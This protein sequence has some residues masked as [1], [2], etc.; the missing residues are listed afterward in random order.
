[1]AIR[2][3]SASSGSSGKTDG[4]PGGVPGSVTWE[5]APTELT[6]RTA[7]VC[8]YGESGSGRTTF[9]LTAPG[10][11]ALLHASEKIEGIVQPFAKK[12]DIRILDFGGIFE[13]S[14]QEIAKQA[15]VK[16][17][18]VKAAID[19]AFG[20]ARTIVLDTH[21]E[22]WELM[23]LARFGKLS[24]VLP[25]HYGPLNAEWRTLFKR[26][27]Q[28]DSVNLVCI[29][30]IRERYRNDKPTGKMEQAGQ[31]EMT[32]FSDAVVRTERGKNGDF[33]GVI[34]KGWMN[35]PSEGMELDGEMLT[36]GWVLGLITGT[37]KE[38]WER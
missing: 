36:F 10:P 26:F 2:T 38:T 32:Y 18:E 30:Q 27:R 35:A 13:G 24:Q 11:I 22:F 23:R 4:S 25:H 16:V 20:W 31:K 21:T 5:A 19:D 29:G 9:A 12:K 15:D 7:F 8:T 3:K 28:Q 34:E 17:R 37:D 6:R 1:M 14:E 33:G